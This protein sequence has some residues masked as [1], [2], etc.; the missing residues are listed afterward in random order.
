MNERVRREFLR[1]CRLMRY[2]G[3]ALGMREKHIG[4]RHEDGHYSLIIE[5][6]P[7]D[8]RSKSTASI[9]S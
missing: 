4:Q 5:L 1:C 6:I 3:K 9:G 8:E 7:S 2:V